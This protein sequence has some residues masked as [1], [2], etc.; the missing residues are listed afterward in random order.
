MK[1]AIGD[2][3]TR[4][5]GSRSPALFRPTSL[6]VSMACALAAGCGP[7]PDTPAGRC[8][9]VVHAHLDLQGGVALVG[10]TREEPDGSVEIEYEGT[11]PMNLPVRGSAVCSFGASAEGALAL[12]QA[13]VDGIPL[14][15]DE[16]AAIRRKLPSGG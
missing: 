12:Q 1:I 4:P 15:Q 11:G 16:I 8:A 2:P 9:A 14:G 3:G 10:K 13:S 7:S 5:A 6:L